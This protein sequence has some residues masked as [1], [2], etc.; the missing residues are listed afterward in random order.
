MGRPA[1]H[2]AQHP[3][4]PQSVNL[5]GLA[6]NASSLYSAATGNGILGNAVSTVG[7]WLGFGGAAASGLGLTAAAGAG[8]TLAA[9]GTG[10]GLTGGL[11]AG[12]G[13]AAGGGLGITAGSAGAGA[14]GAGLGTSAAAGGTAAAAGTGL[15]GALAAIP[16]WGWA[17]AGVAVLGSMLSKPSTPHMGAL[18]EY[19][20]STGLKT[21][22]GYQSGS[23]GT[24]F[25]GVAMNAETEKLTA[26]MA[27]SIVGILDGTAAAFGKQVGFSA[28]TAF[29]DDTSKDG[30]WGGLRIALG[31]LDIVNWNDDRTSR[32][33]PKEFADGE[34]GM[35]QYQATAAL[36]VRDALYAI[37]LPG[38]AD[39]ALAALGEAP[40]VE[41]L[42][43]AVTQIN[44]VQAA[45]QRIGMAMPQIAAMSDA[46]I[47]ALINAAGGAD[48]LAGGLA[49]FYANYFSEAE[50]TTVATRM[51][52]DEL[53]TLGYAMPSSRDEFRAWVESAIDAGES[54]AKSAAGLLRLEGAV[55][56]VLPATENAAD[57]ID[58]LAGALEREQQERK[59]LASLAQDQHGLWA[60]LA[61]AQGDHATAAQRRYWIETAGMT[62]AEQAA[63]DYN[64]SIREQIAA[65]NDAAAAVQRASSAMSS[66]GDTRFDLENELLTLSGNTSEVA[67]RQ[68]ERDLA[69]MSAGLDA[70]Q[71]AKI[72]AAYDYNVALREQIKA[73]QDAQA[74][75]EA[76]AQAQAQASQQAA[77]AAQQL[78]AAWQGITDS[79]FDEVKRI[80][81][82]TSG[83]TAA[84]LAGAQSEFAIATAQARAGDQEAAKRL[85][86]LSRAMLSLAES[87]AAS[88][89]D[90]R[91]I[92]GRTAASLAQTGGG[93]AQS[94]G[95]KV[96]AFDVGT[97]YVPH[98]MLAMIHKGEAIVPE[99]FNPAA[100][101]LQQ[102]ALDPRAVQLL[103]QIF[104]VLQSMQAETRS[105]AVSSAS[106]AKALTRVMTPARDALRTQEKVSA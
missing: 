78:T 8:T 62:A 73:Q 13:L 77:Q 4:Q 71:A 99:R 45:L 98:D 67:R 54:G 85:P 38:W 102:A 94:Y 90:L 7:G 51:V 44:A 5:L 61:E 27:Q 92:Q 104:D 59:T 105:T 17:L 28:A 49:S 16:G 18:A 81:G 40:S 9:A 34:A 84:S 82:I 89:L 96:P 74:A 68:R 42:A 87:S 2:R 63:Y 3:G 23:Y 12:Y 24:G 19:S 101:G 22:D 31:G 60:D 80:R 32:W 76:A 66:L 86:E 91:R 46:A 53:A 57:A 33:A 83:N 69:E 58:S 47:T 75:A 72:T 21:G 29:A 30:A 50:K 1:R 52:T 95:L 37:D 36:G 20:A 65:A 56:A 10:L 97:N 48:V 11:G 15:S 26:G 93:L 41:G 64:Q 79:I 55:A 6:S 35:K 103:G 70:E 25:G 14:I 43:A 100:F 106:V 88:L 39:N